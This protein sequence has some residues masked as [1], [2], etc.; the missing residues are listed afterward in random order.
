MKSALECFDKRYCTFPRDDKEKLSGIPIKKNKR[1]GRN[2]L[3]HQEYRR[4]IKQLKIAMGEGNWNKGGRP[5]GSGLKVDIV[6][7]WQQAHPNKKKADCIRET[8]LDRK[9]VSKYWSGG[10]GNDNGTNDS[11]NGA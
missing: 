6:T 2:K 9:T 5:Q 7:K 4:G 10:K 3:K 1:N 8:G 11:K